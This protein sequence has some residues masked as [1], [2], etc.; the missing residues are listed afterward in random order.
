MVFARR[1][2]ISVQNIVS[3]AEINWLA[4]S[5]Y[6]EE[7]LTKHLT[8]GLGPGEDGMPRYCDCPEWACEVTLTLGTGQLQ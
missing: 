5:I 3:V 4:L 2:I 6:T 8:P 7:Q 1:T